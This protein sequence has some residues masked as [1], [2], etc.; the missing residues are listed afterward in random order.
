MRHMLLRSLSFFLLLLPGILG[1]ASPAQGCELIST[2]EPWPPYQY[3]D[4]GRLTGL[5]IEL[6]EAI[7]KEAGCALHFVRQPWARALHDLKAGTL[8]VASGASRNSER[9]TFAYFSNE[10]RKENMVLFVKA[11]Q[12]KDHAIKDVEDLARMSDFRLGITRNYFYGEAF[13]KVVKEGTFAGQLSMVT[14]TRQNFEK[15]RLGRIDGLL[16]DLFV[17][18]YLA[19]ELELQNQVAVYPLVVHS[20]SIHLMFSKAGVD[21][22]T[23]ARMNRALKTIRENGTYQRIVERYEP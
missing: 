2:W 9:E 8:D 10:Y 4:N 19:R 21:P 11:S 1:A 18:A 12:V 17:G 7:A 6:L 23:V 20:D 5:D 14:R 16:A 22:A 3:I 13:E 15:L